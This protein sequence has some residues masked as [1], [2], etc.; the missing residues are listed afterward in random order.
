MKINNKNKY[1]NQKIA[2]GTKP[3]AFFIC[4]KLYV[5]MNLILD[6]NIFE[7]IKILYKIS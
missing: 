1:I 3:N 5:F 6:K 7:N 2:L 4:E